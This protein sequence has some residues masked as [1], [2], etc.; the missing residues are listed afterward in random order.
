MGE[1]GGFPYG[2]VRGL[3]F[4]SKGESK[5]GERLL[6]VFKKLISLEKKRWYASL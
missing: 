4:R 6:K 3:F 2:G 5:G 1:R